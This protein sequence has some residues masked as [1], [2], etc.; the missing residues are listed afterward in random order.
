MH[1]GHAP[2]TAAELTNQCPTSA[3]TRP[4][5]AA[6][7]RLLA[8]LA[9]IQ[10]AESGITLEFGTKKKPPPVKP[11]AVEK[12]DEEKPPPQAPPPPPFVSRGWLMKKGRKRR[13]WKRRYF[14][15][16]DDWSSISY[17]EDER[18]LKER[19][20]VNLG[21]ARCDLGLDYVPKRAHVFAFTVRARDDVYHLECSSEG[22]RQRWL[23][24]L[25]TAST[26]ARD[27]ARAEVEEER[28]QARRAE[29]GEMSDEAAAFLSSLSVD[30]LLGDAGLFHR[31]NWLR[32]LNNVLS[33]ERTLEQMN[34]AL[35]GIYVVEAMT[36]RY[37]GDDKLSVK[38]L[39]L[40]PDQ[41]AHRLGL[42]LRW[43]QRLVCRV[44][45]YRP[46]GGGLPSFLKTAAHLLK[47]IDK[48]VTH[49]LS[50]DLRSTLSGRPRCE[51]LLK[52][53]TTAPFPRL[54]RVELIRLPRLILEK[55]AIRV[56][57]DADQSLLKTVYGIVPKEVL[58]GMLERHLNDALASP[59]T[60]ALCKWDLPDPALQEEKPLV[61]KLARAAETSWKGIEAE[62]P[63]ATAQVQRGAGWF[64]R[65][66]SRRAV[67]ARGALSGAPRLLKVE[68]DSEVAPEW[69]PANAVSILDV[70]PC[71]DSDEDGD[72]WRPGPPKEGE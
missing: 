53:S 31:H 60:L 11:K 56:D 48:S 7:L 35:R 71:A 64:R 12:K 50:F 49:P 57:K 23:R 36:L 40:R 68:D 18:C 4:A 5:T 54:S 70:E 8:L 32:T 25:K 59:K 10:A 67:A 42:D 51:L 61:G 44:K 63:V 27:D 72:G 20:R 19:G 24:T 43:P 62:F 34:K 6:M 29:A 22:E 17:Y 3:P 58:V 28:R 30:G 69:D 38:R 33:S 14:V 66:V 46:A 2:A 9:L 21:G 55:D 65:E 26:S 37:E 15:L 13:N 39:E 16:S 45:G 52:S 47:G 41:D 1:S